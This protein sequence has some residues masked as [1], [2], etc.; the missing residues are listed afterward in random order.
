MKNLDCFIALRNTIKTQLFEDS[1]NAIQNIISSLAWNDSIYR[2][3][4]EGLRLARNRS[5]HDRIPKSLVDYVHRAHIAYVVMALRKLYDDKKEGAW[6]V[7]SLRTITQKIVDNQHLFTRRNFVSY[8]GMPYEESRNLD[9]KI[10]ATIRGRHHQ[11]DLLCG[12]TAVAA[13]KPTDRVD[14]KVPDSIN[15]GTALRPEI[16][17]FANKFLAHSA[18]Q[19]NRPDEKYAFKGLTLTKIQLQYKNAIWASQ[20]IGRFL[21]EPILTEVPTPQFDVLD[22]W[23]KGL[24]DK[25]IKR[26]LLSYW[27]ERMDWWRRWTEYYWSYD[28]LF[29]R[30]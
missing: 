24:F 6:A 26:R 15:Q 13:R 5:A 16:G 21:C 27:Y 8:D 17:I 4:N 23:D 11:F 29:L 9:W 3:F 18:A 19:K 20:Q 12:G 28:R 1:E 22:Q 25:P 2:T 10:T 7:N 30:P 14:P